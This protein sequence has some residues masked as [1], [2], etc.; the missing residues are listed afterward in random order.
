MNSSTADL[1][2][3]SRASKTNS[4]TGVR[5]WS[6]TFFALLVTA[7]LH[8]HDLG[9]WAWDHDE[10]PALI[11]LGLSNIEMTGA[12]GEQAKKLP[13]LLPVWYESQRL[14]LRFLPIDEWGARVL[15]ATCGA[16]AVVLAFYAVTR[17]WGFG[18]GL[19]FLIL[20]NGSQCYIW[21]SQQNR[22]YSMAILFLTL[23]W[24]VDCLSRASLGS[25]LG[26]VLF[27]TLAVLSHSLLVVVFLIAFVAA[28]LTALVRW[29][30]WTLVIHTGL[31]AAVSLAIYVGYLRPIMQG[32]VSGG[33]G[34]TN[35]LVSFVAQI[36]MPTLALGLLGALLSLRTAESRTRMGWWT[37]LAV[38]GLAF[39]AMT[40]WIM[41]AWNPRYGLFFMPPFFM[42]AAYAVTT[43][44]QLLRSPALQVGWYLIVCLLLLPK[45]ASH[46]QDGS[47][48]DF[49][50]AAAV[51]LKHTHEGQKVLSN[52]PETL[53][54]YLTDKTG[55]KVDWLEQTLPTSEF[56]VVFSSNAWE[57]LF[58]PPNRQGQVL[59]EIRT[60]R[61]DEQSH[62]VRVYHVDA[63]P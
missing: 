32:W 20:V 10:V 40:P 19:A 45:L 11:E 55:I 63:L 8:F 51:V 61:F 43:V 59:A 27:T 18:F 6:A 12:T 60:R 21:L 34:G 31:S 28:C 14:A 52:W 56:L 29:T 35:V 13:R 57:P 41:K 9:R 62:I 46:Y 7:F 42:L 22:F 3:V 47:R 30:S 50:S 5:L 44:A 17:Y 24:M 26:I 38:G 39:L 54:Y 49:R 33:T 16:L 58:Q 4:T 25:V 1:Q 36:G 48:H 23:T 53:Q 37:T 15:P 2:R